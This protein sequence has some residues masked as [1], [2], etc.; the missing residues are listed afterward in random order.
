MYERSAIVLER[1]FSNLLGLNKANNLKRNFNNYSELFEKFKVVQQANSEEFAVLKEFQ[2]AENEIEEIQN[3]EEKLY[4]K[5]AKLEYNRDLIFQDIS[6]K[7][8]E[9]EKCSQKIESDI[10]K[11]QEKLVSLREE[12]VEAVKDYNQKKSALSKCKKNRKLA[13]NDYNAIFEQTKNTLENIPEEYIESAKGFAESEIEQD[14]IN[15]LSENG[16]DEK[17]PFNNQVITNAAR[18]GFDI[19]VREVKCYLQAYNLAQKLVNELIEGAVSMELHEKTI[20]NISVELSF[21]SAEKD[22]IVGFLDYERI[23]VIYGKRMHRSLMIDACEKLEQDIEQIE[24]LYKIIEKEVAEKSTKKAYRDLYNKS[25]LMEIE[26]KDAKFKKEK[27]RVNLS[28]GTIMNSNYWRI[29][30]IKNIYTV[31]YRNVVDVFGKDLDEFEIPE[32][33]DDAFDEDGNPIEVQAFAEENDLPEDS[34]VEEYSLEDKIDSALEEIDAIDDTPIEVVKPEKVKKAEASKV[35][36][37]SSVEKTEKNAKAEKVSELEKADKVEEIEKVSKLEK[38]DKVEKAEKL[39]KA[40]TTSKKAEA[41]VEKTQKETSKKE[42]KA[43]LAEEIEEEKLETKSKVEKK[44]KKK[45]FY[46]CKERL[47]DRVNKK[48]ENTMEIEETVEPEI[49]T[50]KKTLKLAKIVKK[51]GRKKV[52]HYT[53]QIVMSEDFNDSKEV[54]EEPATKSKVS[55]AKT[56]EKVKNAIEEFDI[57]GEKYKDIDSRIA[58]LDDLEE[59]ALEDEKED[60]FNNIEEAR[61][62]DLDSDNIAIEDED[63]G[64]ED[65]SLEGLDEDLDE[66]S[67]FN[68]M[69]AEREDEIDIETISKPKHSK[70]KRAKE[71]A[72]KNKLFSGLKKLNS[73]TKKNLVHE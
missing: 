35:E 3:H 11:T 5:N 16:K 4:K 13:E 55:K 39:A 31:F 27:S 1:Y 28:V 57:F 65:E 6:Q 48:L 29:E 44:A 69:E 10:Q 23:T 72:T 24:N 62:E 9:I 26:D 50:S 2:D 71:K 32:D 42:E 70:G 43:V 45:K 53:R 59:Y 54:I 61:L 52:R 68:M 40:E 12:F 58:E 36:K 20:R 38:T 25:Y 14:I 67:I 34:L 33:Q 41:S 51:R 60:N 66:E 18:I 30:G 17:I 7:P 56:E 46:T 64:F 37:V 49:D 8:E 21:L 19:T 63:I 47:S 73:K 15:T 22:Y